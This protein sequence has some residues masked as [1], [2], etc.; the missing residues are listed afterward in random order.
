LS[1]LAPR[2]EAR[3]VPERVLGSPNI[4]YEAA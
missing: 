1:P 2:G 4:S 3:S